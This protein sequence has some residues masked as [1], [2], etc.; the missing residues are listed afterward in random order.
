VF[1]LS[2]P[3]YFYSGTS[4]AQAGVCPGVAMLLLLPYLTF[5]NLS[6][7]HLI[8]NIFTKSWWSQQHI[9]YHISLIWG[10]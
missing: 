8:H 2:F 9:G 3:H 5:T 6:D 4:E 1:D 7:L 10:V